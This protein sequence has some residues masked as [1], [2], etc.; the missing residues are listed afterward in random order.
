[1]GCMRA[2][3]LGLLSNFAILYESTLLALLSSFCRNTK[4]LESLVWFVARGVK[5]APGVGVL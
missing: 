2:P 4:R 5:N 3:L 1:M